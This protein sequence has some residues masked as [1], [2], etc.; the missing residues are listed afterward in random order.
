MFDIHTAIISGDATSLPEVV[1]D[2]ALICSATDYNAV[3]ENM[4]RIVDDEKL[5]NSL[6]EKGRM[7]RQKF[8]WQLTSERLWNCIEK[9]LK[10]C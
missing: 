3:A 6:I 10:L 4:Y 8:S 5:R 2:A 1:G 9:A 7:Q